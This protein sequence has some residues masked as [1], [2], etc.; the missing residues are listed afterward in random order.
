[1]VP[2]LDASSEGRSICLASLESANDGDGPG[3][4]MRRLLRSCQIIVT[5]DGGRAPDVLV[6]SISTTRCTGRPCAVGQSLRRSKPDPLGNQVV[7][8]IRSSMVGAD[9]LEPPTLSV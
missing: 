2:A 7:P 3:E 1:M 9:G 5:M 4:R 6:P 8:M